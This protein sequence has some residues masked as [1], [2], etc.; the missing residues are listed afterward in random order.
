M[1][2]TPIPPLKFPQ[3]SL[4]QKI[5]LA[6][7]ELDK[8]KSLLGGGISSWGTFFPCF[9]EHIA[10]IFYELE[11][12][13][14]EKDVIAPIA[15]ISHANKIVNALQQEKSSQENERDVYQGQL[16]NLRKK[17]DERLDQTL[18]EVYNFFNQVADQ[19]ETLYLGVQVLRL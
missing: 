5:V 15:P 13:S 1:D 10:S 19:M 4:V 2:L 8:L 17:D 9:Q 7:Q 14:H 18:K 3:S 12:K 11:K 16:D 6:L